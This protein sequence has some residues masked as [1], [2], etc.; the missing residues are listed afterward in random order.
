MHITIITYIYNITLFENDSIV[1]T[2]SILSWPF[3]IF[4]GSIQEI[5]QIHC[6]YGLLRKMQIVLYLLDW[7]LDY[8]IPFSLLR[9][10]T[11]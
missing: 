6:S 8:R 9:S 7:N 1:F 4:N 2:F 10:T 3:C 5:S 11:A